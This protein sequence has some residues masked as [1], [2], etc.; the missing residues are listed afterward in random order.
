MSKDA[1]AT[2]PYTVS[3]LVT[4]IHELEFAKNALKETEQTLKRN[5]DVIKSFEKTEKEQEAELHR[6]ENIVKKIAANLE[7]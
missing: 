4:A 7:K 1:D 2:R 3:D 5:R 6:R